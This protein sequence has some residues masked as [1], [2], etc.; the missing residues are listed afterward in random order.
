MGFMDLTIGGSDNASDFTSEVVETVRKKCIKELKN[1]ANEYNTPGYINVALLLKSLISDENEF[2]FTYKEQWGR[3]WK[4]IL[5]SFLTDHNYSDAETNEQF[6]EL[7][8]WVTEMNKIC[9][10]NE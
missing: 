10:E 6:Q 5:K 7:K 2:H 3:V 4:K 1:E 8:E 9:Q